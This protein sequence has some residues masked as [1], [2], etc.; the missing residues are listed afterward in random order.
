MNNVRRF[1]LINK[2]GAEY[3]LNNYGHAWLHDPDG[4]GW[5]QTL[6][7]VSVG[8]AFVTLRTG[9]EAPS[10]NGEIIFISYEA[11]QEFLDFVQIGGLVLAYM[12]LSTWR[13]L[14]CVVQIEKSEIKPEN[15]RLI[16][17]ITFLA[18][19]YWYEALQVYR[20]S[21]E[22]HESDKQYDYEYAYTYGGDGAGAVTVYN[23][24]LE[25]YFSL[26]M[27]GEVRNPYWRVMKNGE[28]VKEGKVNAT[29]SAG[30]KLV[31]NTHPAKMEIAEYTVGGEFVRD[32]Y[33]LSDFTT[34]RIFALPSGTS[35]VVLADSSLTP[36][37]G[38]LEVRKR[39]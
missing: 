19:S 14:D 27:L 28:I 24:A 33:G 21:S 32:L 36:P 23:G 2:I 22:A 15:D 38:W 26:T 25:S 3:N 4:L 12:P 16:C 17:P 34:E 39:V 11:Y 37:V 1:K 5:A 10:P 30:N 13:Y 6:E 20:T 35:T 18:Q 31:V 8:D 7:T 9:V 29:I